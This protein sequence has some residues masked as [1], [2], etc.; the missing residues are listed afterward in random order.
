MSA[1]LF[2]EN[3]LFKDYNMARPAKTEAPE[4]G[5]KLANARNL[6]NMT[7]AQLAEKLGLSIKT[8]DHYERRCPNPSLNFVERVAKELNISM[9]ELLG[10]ENK[11]HKPGPVSKLEKQIKQVQQ[12]PKDE[13]K[14]VSKLLDNVI[15]NAK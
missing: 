15:L 7:Q 2:L 3:K 14:F 5:K 11:G 6:A 12:L 10:E 8:I 1:I 9:L 13:Q 4:F